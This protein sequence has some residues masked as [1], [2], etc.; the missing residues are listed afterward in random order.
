[1]V[2]LTIAHLAQSLLSLYGLATSYISI[3]KL[4]KYEKQSE[5]AAKWSNTA[6]HQLHKTRTTQA[7]GALSVRISFCPPPFLPSSFSSVS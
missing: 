1:M 7:S 5:K 3:T 6:A 2:L 4:Q